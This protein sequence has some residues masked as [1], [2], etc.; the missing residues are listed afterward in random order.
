MK[1][2]EQ[3]FALL[4]LAMYVTVTLSGCASFRSTEARQ[5]DPEPVGTYIVLVY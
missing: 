1:R 4:G 2:F 3:S 5:A